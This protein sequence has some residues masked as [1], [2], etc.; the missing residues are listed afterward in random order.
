M[1]F[2]LACLAVLV[3]DAVAIAAV[4]ASERRAKA[5]E[6]H[7]AREALA[8]IGLRVDGDPNGACEMHGRIAGVDLVVHQRASRV[9]PSVERDA[10]EVTSV[11][12]ALPVADLVVCPASA[13]DAFF[14]PL[15]TAPRARTGDARFDAAFAV[16]GAAR[17]PGSPFRGDESVD[18]PRWATPPVLEALLELG[19]AWMR[20]RDGTAEIAFA[21]LAIDDVGRAAMVAANVANAV[22]GEPARPV[23]RGARV[24]VARERL[25]TS[26]IVLTTLGIGAIGPGPAIVMTAA[27]LAPLRDASQEVVCGAGGRLLVSSVDVGDGTSYGLYFSNAPSASIALHFVF[28][29]V[30]AA[31]VIASVL[32]AWV[33]VRRR[34]G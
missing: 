24:A 10:A 18:A 17:A 13:V 14:G 3:L 11:E 23:G 20:V 32:A 15:P 27:F 6:A 22:R 31:A 4:I 16:F 30:F 28:T 5:R 7:R 21:P 33:V 9:R 1:T 2:L 34:G 29:S 19:L 26:S 12:L 25:A 8:Q